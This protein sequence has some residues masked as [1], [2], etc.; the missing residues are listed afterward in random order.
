MPA[1]AAEQFRILRFGPTPAFEAADPAD[2]ASLGLGREALEELPLGL[3]LWARLTP[4]GEAK[5]ETGERLG[6]EDWSTGENLWLVELISP[7]ATERNKLQEIMLL[8]LI[9]GPFASK[10][11]S[12]H[13]TDPL[14]GRRA[15]VDIGG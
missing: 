1:V 2:F 4:E 14:T 12:M 9:N 3:A 13:R 10:K 8:D 11:F 5:L 6:P 7:F 15:R